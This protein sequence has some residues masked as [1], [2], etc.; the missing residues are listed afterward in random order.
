[1]A[2]ALRHTPEVPLAQPPTLIT[3]RISPD[4]GRL[5]AVDDSSAIFELFRAS[6]EL[7][8]R[9]AG[10]GALEG[11]GDEAEPADPRRANVLDDLRDDAEERQGGR[12]G[13]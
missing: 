3:A 5:A 11:A 8:N 9:A 7:S 13:L 4:T 12:A 6:E 10:A 1:M 2:R